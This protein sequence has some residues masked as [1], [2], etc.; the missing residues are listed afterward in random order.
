L[1]A[2]RG[3][4]MAAWARFCAMPITAGEKVAVLRQR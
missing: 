1:F 3:Q 2:K 4:L